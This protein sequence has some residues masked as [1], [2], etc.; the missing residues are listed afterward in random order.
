[1]ASIAVLLGAV[2]VGGY[3]YR[4]RS[5]YPTEV[6]AGVLYRS[7]LPTKRELTHLG[8]LN[9]KTV[10]NLCCPDEHEAREEPK[11]YQAE[12][13][14]CQE[15][16]LEF[17]SISISALVPTDEQVKQFLEVMAK[18]KSGSGGAVLVH[19]AQGRNRTGMMVAAY[20]VVIED[21]PGDKALKEMQDMGADSDGEKGAKKADWLMAISR[22]R[23]K[24]RAISRPTSSASPDG[25][26]SDLT[27][28][29]T[30]PVD[31]KLPAPG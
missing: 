20:R 24:W 6:T 2:L 17:I 1:M 22:D 18:H 16:G 31:L 12:K 9:I 4:Q 27:L 19:C 13:Q 8:D 11:A 28:S 23:Q 26:K 14:F 15:H 7:A 29:A 5:I 3:I 10:V 21:W 25:G 30:A